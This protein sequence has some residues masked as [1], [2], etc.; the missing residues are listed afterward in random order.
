MLTM[1]CCILRP[2]IV[3]PIAIGA[4]AIAVAVFIPPYMTTAFFQNLSHHV[5][6]TNSLG[7]VYLFVNDTRHSHGTKSLKTWR[8]LEFARFS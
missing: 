1:A 8:L 5:Q 6:S 7:D 3:G 4:V 2:I